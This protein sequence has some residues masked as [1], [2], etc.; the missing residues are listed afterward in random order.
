MGNDAEFDVFLCH[1][2]EDKD[3]VI[4]IAER[5][6]RNGLRPWLDIWELQPGLSWIDALEE[7]IGNIATAA[8]FVGNS[9]L[10]PWQRQEIRAF[11]NEF[12]SRGCPLIPVI[13]ADA[14]KKPDLPIFLKNNTWVD[15]RRQRPDPMERL[16]WG[17]TGKRPG[18]KRLLVVENTSPSTTSA[19]ERE[20]SAKSETKE[21]GPAEVELVSAVGMNYEQLRNLL[22]AGEWREADEETLRVMLAVAKREEQGWLNS[23]SME[24]FPCEDIRTIDQLWVNY[25]NGRFG[26]SV[27]KKIWEEVGGSSQAWRREWMRFGDRVR[28]KTG[29]T[30]ISKTDL[31]FKTLAPR[32]HLPSPVMRSWLTWK[33]FE[34]FCG[35]EED[36]NAVVFLSRKDF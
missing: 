28:W 35:I 17:V 18:R 6:E 23:K 7:Q 25:S 29:R 5:L 30:W 27:Q 26:F 15:F 2:S 32:G 1:N 12:V 22:A 9:G 24:S 8:V 13:L 33:Y 4:E 34:M 20:G 31:I 19:E 16:T 11:L 21:S 3:A 14:P 10:G 36:W